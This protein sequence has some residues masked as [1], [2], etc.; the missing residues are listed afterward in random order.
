MCRDAELIKLAHL[1]RDHATETGVHPVV[2]AAQWVAAGFSAEA[3]AGWIRQGV[4][5]PRAAQ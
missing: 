4:N 5:S 3:A 2:L 1:V